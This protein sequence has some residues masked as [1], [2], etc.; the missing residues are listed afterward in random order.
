[1]RLFIRPGRRRRLHDVTFKR[2]VSAEESAE[3]ES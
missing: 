2:E 3:T 1:M